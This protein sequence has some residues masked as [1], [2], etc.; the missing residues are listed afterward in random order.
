ML[1]HDSVSAM[2]KYSKSLS[3]SGT[4]IFWITHPLKYLTVATQR[5]W[6]LC[7]N[8][9]LT[10]LSFVCRSLLIIDFIPSHSVSSS[11]Y[12]SQ[13]MFIRSPRITIPVTHIL[14]DL[15]HMHFIGP[16]G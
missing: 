14:Y 15:N 10:Y 16:K 7:G 1:H 5:D 4:A 6:T 8:N 11:T 2:T 12:E 3:E 13:L 9:I